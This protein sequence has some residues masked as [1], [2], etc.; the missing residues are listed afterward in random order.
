MKKRR[1][2]RV[3]V[4]AAWKNDADRL[5]AERS[6]R[7]DEQRESRPMGMWAV[8]FDNIGT[9]HWHQVRGPIEAVPGSEV[10]EAYF[11]G[12]PVGLSTVESREAAAH[13]REALLHAERIE[14]QRQIRL[15]EGQLRSQQ[16]SLDKLKETQ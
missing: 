5:F 8:W 2:K 15:L 1:E 12:E 11:P 14:R 13:F 7:W 3:L 10:S 9:A 16:T 6:A 4:D